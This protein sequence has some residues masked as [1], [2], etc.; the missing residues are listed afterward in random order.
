MK[1]LNLI[2]GAVAAL[3]VACSIAVVAADAS[4]GPRPGR[5]MGPPPEALAAC[6]GKAV[7]DAVS[8]SLPDGH[9]IAGTC[10]LMFRPDAAPGQ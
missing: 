9:S 5:P 4:S 6:A 7:G 8:V 10:Q 1:I 2:T 3:A